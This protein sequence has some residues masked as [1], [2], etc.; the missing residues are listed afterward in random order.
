MNALNFSSISVDCTYIITL[1]TFILYCPFYLVSSY[2]KNNNMKKIE[3][4]VLMM[5]D[6]YLSSSLVCS[7]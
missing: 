3:R 1:H 6:C 2:E 4:T 7:W 5:E